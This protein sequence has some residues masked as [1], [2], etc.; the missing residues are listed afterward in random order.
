[1]MKKVKE[2]ILIFFD[3]NKVLETWYV[4]NVWEPAKEILIGKLMELDA[5]I[6]K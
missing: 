2:K 1:M 5:Y 4:K 6:K 3:T